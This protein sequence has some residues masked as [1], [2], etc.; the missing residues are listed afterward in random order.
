MRGLLEQSFLAHGLARKWLP[1]L[2]QTMFVIRAGYIELLF[3]QPLYSPPAK[4][5]IALEHD[6]QRELECAAE[7]VVVP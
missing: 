1:I 4:G 6:V 3:A 2:A 5:W 7:R